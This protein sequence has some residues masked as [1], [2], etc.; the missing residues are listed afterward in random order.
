MSGV[1]VVFLV[2]STPTFNLGQ[3]TNKLKHIL[4]DFP[5]STKVSYHGP[6]SKPRPKEPYSSSS[7]PKPNTTHAH[8]ELEISPLVSVEESSEE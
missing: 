3:T 7:P 4:T 1:E 5:Q 2:V 6:G 8:L